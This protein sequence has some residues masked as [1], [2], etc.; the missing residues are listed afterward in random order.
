MSPTPDDIDLDIRKEWARLRS[1]LYETHD[2]ALTTDGRDGHRW[3]TDRYV[4]LDVTGSPAIEGLEDG[5]YKL[6]ATRGLQ[7]GLAVNED[8]QNFLGGGIVD[9]L[10]R[11]ESGANWVCA[12]PSEWSVAEHPGKAM[13]L[14]C[15]GRP[16]L[17]GESTWT[18]LHRHFPE[19][20]VEY[21]MSSGRNLFRVWE[22]NGNFD[23]GSRIVAYVAGIQIP[24][25]QEEIAGRMCADSSESA[26]PERP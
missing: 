23:P 10:D 17:I 15:V 11:V 14:S 1:L 13:L 12:H 2:L 4:L 21:D 5:A 6:L 18:T 20:R 24:E 19:A 8:Y 7:G 3:L 22:P 16:V 9:Y 26:S 25:G